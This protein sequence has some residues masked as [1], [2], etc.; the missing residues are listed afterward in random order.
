[1]ARTRN[2]KRL[3]VIGYTVLSLVLGVGLLVLSQ[4]IRPDSPPDE[5]QPT[6]TPP[7][8]QDRPAPADEAP[9][10]NLSNMMVL[11][12]TAALIGTVIGIGWIVIDIR[13]SRPA[14][15]TQTKFPRKR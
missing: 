13:N 3:K 14:W 9:A 10:E 8:N 15:K 7:E 11:F 5:P 2:T 12:G 4:A 1:M 6:S